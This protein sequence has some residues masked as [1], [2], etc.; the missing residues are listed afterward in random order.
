[1]CELVLSGYLGRNLKVSQR[2]THKMY[3]VQWYCIVTSAINLNNLLSMFNF[4]LATL[5]WPKFVYKTRAT[6]FVPSAFRLVTQHLYSCIRK[7]KMFNEIRLLCVKKN[8]RLLLHLSPYLYG[9]THTMFPNSWA[10][11]KKSI[12]WVT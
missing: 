1:M 5:L 8:C 3:Q 2:N 7:D 6:L 4:K 11:R 10:C 12:E 9:E